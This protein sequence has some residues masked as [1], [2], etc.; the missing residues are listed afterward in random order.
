[1]RRRGDDLVAHEAAVDIGELLV[2]ARRALYVRRPARPVTVTAPSAQLHGR[3]VAQVVAQHVARAL[4]Q[5]G[6]G[7]H[8][9]GEVARHC[10]TSRPSCQMVKPTSGRA[11]AWRRT[12]STQCASSVASLFKICAARGGEEQP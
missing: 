10:S 9:R 4:L 1:M 2:G 12:A 5:G 11:S 8:R 3:R 6:V 7:V